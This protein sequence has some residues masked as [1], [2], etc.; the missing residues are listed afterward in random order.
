MKENE[1]TTL[2]FLIKFHVIDNILKKGEI[3]YEKK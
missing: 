2:Y 1:K 3:N